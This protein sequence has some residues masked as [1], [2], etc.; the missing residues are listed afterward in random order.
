MMLRLF[1]TLLF[2]SAVCGFVC[3]PNY[4]DTIKCPKFTPEEC[5]VRLSIEASI[6]ECCAGCIRWIEVDQPCPFPASGVPL[7]SE[8]K[9]GLV[10][11][12][13]SHLCERQS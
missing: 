8:C 12:P 13:K 7:Q 3:P 11:D 1:G 2:V 6:C 10:C 5:S 9:P 4:C